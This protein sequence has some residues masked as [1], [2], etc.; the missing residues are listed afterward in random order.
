MH[1][2]LALRRPP[3]Q[4]RVTAKFSNAALYCRS[5]LVPLNPVT[6]KGTGSDNFRL[7]SPAMANNHSNQIRG[8][9]R[10][11]AAGGADSLARVHSTPRPMFWNLPQAWRSP[12]ASTA[13]GLALALRWG[14]TLAGVLF[15]TLPRGGNQLRN[16]LLGGFLRAPRALDRRSL[17][18]LPGVI[19]TALVDSRGT[20]QMVV[21]PSV[22]RP[23]RGA[24]S[25]GWSDSGVRS[26][27]GSQARDDS[28]I[29][30]FITG[31]PGSCPRGTQHRYSS[32]G[33]PVHYSTVPTS[34]QI[35]P[36]AL[37]PVQ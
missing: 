1:G 32:P 4:G 30:A 8:Q 27:R 29:G 37:I 17:G 28:R 26:A 24:S 22:E 36:K 12:C 31:F 18:W 11:M 7:G 16:H 14:L 10:L 34:T 6:L 21:G 33:H 19:G 5:S 35:V 3:S 9:P 20:S 2:Q 13:P 23:C 25:E 15:L